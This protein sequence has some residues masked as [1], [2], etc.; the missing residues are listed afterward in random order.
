MHNYLKKIERMVASGELT[1]TVGL[2][3][4]TVA[5]DDW[6]LVFSGRECNCDPDITFRAGIT[7]KEAVER[8]RQSNRSFRKAVQSKQQQ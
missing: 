5:H 3:D 7:I 4:L 6:C 2:N 8:A 1:P